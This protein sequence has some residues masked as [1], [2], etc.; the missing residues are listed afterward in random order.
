MAA[1]DAELSKVFKAK[2]GWERPHV[3]FGNGVQMETTIYGKAKDIGQSPPDMNVIKFHFLPVMPTGQ[4]IDSPYLLLPNEKK[5]IR[6]EAMKGFL[7]LADA[8][9]AKKISIPDLQT[10]EDFY[11]YAFP[12]LSLALFLIQNCGFHGYARD[13]KVWLK[14]SEFAS[15]E[16]R[17]HMQQKYQK[18]LAELKT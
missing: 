16:N 10:H 1:N 9:A 8:L 13:G 12:N 3:A 7:E 17:S 14:A 15:Q 2:G 18:F 6:V 5:R 11:L 4:R